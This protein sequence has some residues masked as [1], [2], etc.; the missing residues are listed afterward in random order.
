[1]TILASNHYKTAEEEFNFEKRYAKIDAI[2]WKLV[3]GCVLIGFLLAPIN[4]TWSLAIGMGS[5]ALVLALL[6]KFFLTN[7]NK[8]GYWLS[9]IL[10]IQVVQFIGQM[11]GSAE[12][13]FLF[14][15]AIAYLIYYQDWKVFMPLTI[16]YLLYHFLFAW[17]EIG[18]NNHM[19]HYYINYAAVSW[20]SLLYHSVPVLLMTFVCALLAINFKNSQKIHQQKKELL[21]KKDQTIQ[22]GIDFAEEIAKGNFDYEFNVSEDEDQLAI[23]LDKMRIQLVEAKEKEAKERY[24]TNGVTQVNEILRSNIND[25]ELLGENLLKVLTKYVNANQAWFFIVNEEEV[26]PFLELK[27]CY[28]FN[29]KKFLEKKIIYGEGLIGQAVLEK[30]MVHLT[31]IPHNYASIVSGAGEVEPLSILIVPLI[32]NEKVM[33]AIEF[34]SL[35]KFNSLEIE[36]VKKAA[37]GIASTLTNVSN[38]EKTKKLLE[39]SQVQREQLK[40][41]EEEM[42]QN[43]EELMATQTEMEKIQSIS[44]KQVQSYSIFFNEN[45]EALLITDEENKILHVNEKMTEIFAYNNHEII[46]NYLGTFLDFERLN[47]IA[48][49]YVLTQDSI[50]VK[51]NTPQAIYFTDK[52]GNYSRISLKKSISKNNDQTYFIFSIQAI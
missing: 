4:D 45:P 33:G 48:K 20:I 36:Y 21:K 27:S 16:V 49:A 15:I 12:S 2:S 34:V 14:F 7:K 25:V 9:A 41:Q 35:G 11:H 1:M 19:G 50:F 38:N 6:W 40:A 22:K 13:H 51:Q 42:R 18:G 28:A 31:N 37:E 8:G 32:Y 43:L 5:I 30:D 52:N 3:L 17:L 46:G 47:E 39:E 10:G 23:S 26:E 44:E 24:L 29:R